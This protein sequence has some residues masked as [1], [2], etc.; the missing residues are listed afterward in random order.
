MKVYMICAYVCLHLYGYMCIGMPMHS[1][2]HACR[3]QR[4]ISSVFPD[5][6]PP[7]LLSLNPVPG[8]P[9][10]APPRPLSAGITVRPPWGTGHLN[11]AS[12]F[13]CFISE[14]ILPSLPSFKCSILYSIP[15][16]TPN[17][18]QSS[19]LLEQQPVRSHPV[20]I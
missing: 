20:S 2:T 12:C 17:C 16:R 6:S 3:G 4:L 1:C 11:L 18:T 8:S 10:S 9:V 5:C 15:S 13:Q 7:C 19:C 14:V